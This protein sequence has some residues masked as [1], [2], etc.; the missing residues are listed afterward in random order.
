MIDISLNPKRNRFCNG[1]SRRAFIRVGALTPLGLSLGGLLASEKLASGTP[2]R[3]T[4]ARSV[5]LV[6]LGGGLSH[7]DSFDLKPDAP[8][9]VRGKYS[10]IDTVVPGLKI[11]ERLPLMARVIDRVV[12]ARSDYH[13]YDHHG[14][15]TNWLLP[16]RARQMVLSTESRRAF[17]IEQEPEKLR[18]RYGRT[19]AGQSMLLARRLVE[20]GTRFVTVNYGGW[21]H[22]AK[23]FENLD[24][25]LPEFDRALS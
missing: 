7:H 4:R 20:A 12:L 8:D 9:D 25:K 19:T 14:T 23:V 11:G 15:A 21:D 24:K 22:H 16:G 1:W 17:A 13:N 6:Y 5:I 10:P 2:A 18:E 3:R